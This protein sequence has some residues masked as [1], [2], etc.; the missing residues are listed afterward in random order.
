MFMSSLAT[1]MSKGL[2]P[3]SGKGGPFEEVMMNENTDDESEYDTIEIDC[4]E[5]D[6]G[7][8]FIRTEV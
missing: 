5:I 2:D 6:K 7:T 4:D 1:I 3:F 8:L